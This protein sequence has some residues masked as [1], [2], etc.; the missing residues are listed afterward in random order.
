MLFTSASPSA[1]RYSSHGE[2]ACSSCRRETPSR[3]GTSAWIWTSCR[4]AKGFF[5]AGEDEILPLKSRQFML[6]D[7]SGGSLLNLMATLAQACGASACHAP[8]EGLAAAEFAAARNVVLLIIDGLGDHYLRR[9]GA[10]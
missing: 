9:R 4:M 2:N 7:Y 5:Q 1:S 6:P 8:L 10:G 3:I